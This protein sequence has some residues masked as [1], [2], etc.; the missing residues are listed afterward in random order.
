L[1]HHRPDL[2]EWLDFVLEKALQTDPKQRYQ[3]VPEMC[4][5]LQRFAA[6]QDEVKPR[7]QRLIWRNPLTFWQTVSFVLLVLL[8]DLLAGRHGG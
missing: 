4:A 7:R 5:D 3:D 2:P 1:H 6:V 8:L